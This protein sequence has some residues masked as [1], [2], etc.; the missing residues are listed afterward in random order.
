MD[1]GRS[2]RET[3]TRVYIVPSH[4]LVIVRVGED[5]RGRDGAALTNA[6]LPG[7]AAP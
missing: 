4:S 5:G 3:V 6:V 2:R 7:N 1:S